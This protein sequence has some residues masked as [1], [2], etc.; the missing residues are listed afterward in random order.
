MANLQIKGVE[1]DFYEDL[2]RLAAASHRSVSGT[3]L[4]AL[5]EYL[6]KQRKVEQAGSPAQ[7]L[8]ALAGSWEGTGS[9]R[10]IAAGVRRARRSLRARPVF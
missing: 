10:E 5:K 6:A 4:A 2:K 8:L 7:V 1:E 3:V 9:A